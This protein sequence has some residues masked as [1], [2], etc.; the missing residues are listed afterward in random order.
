VLVHVVTGGPWAFEAWAGRFPDFE[1]RV[2]DLQAGLAVERSSMA[3][4]ADRS[5]H[6]RAGRVLAAQR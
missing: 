4:D 3:D 6:G 5:S 2:L 1:V